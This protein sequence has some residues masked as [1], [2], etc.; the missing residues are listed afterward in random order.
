MDRE[1]AIDIGLVLAMSAYAWWLDGHKSAEPDW[2][3][4]EVAV[5]TGACLLA[6]GMRTRAN[7]SAT[8]QSHEGNTWRAFLLGGAPVIAGEISQ[9][10]R[11][12]A[13]RDQY[14]ETRR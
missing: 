12:W 10:I 4:V 2:T 9:A 13:E 8:W 5:G 14:R 7:A 6:A 11:A 3:W 1:S